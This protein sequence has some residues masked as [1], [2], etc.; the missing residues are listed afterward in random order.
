MRPILVTGISGFIGGHVWAALSARDDVWGIYGSAGR[1]P[2]K[3]DRQLH[4]DLS[5]PDSFVEV[6]EELKPRCILHLA[7]LSPK[8][9]RKN[10][11]NAWKVNNSAVREMAKAA[12]RIGA[13]VI[14]A[15]TDILFDGSGCSYRE[16]DPPN[17]INLYGETKK[18]A[19]RSL[20][21]NAANTVVAR[22]ANAYG[23]PKFKGSS[24]S[25]WILEREKKREPITLF[26]DQYRSFIDIVT[27]T[28]ALVELIDHSFKGLLHLGGANRA[29][30]VTFGEMLLNYMKRDSSGI[31][32]LRNADLDPNS[33]NPLDVSFDITLARQVLDT[34]IPGI[35]KGIALVY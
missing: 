29:N 11:I 32:R 12:E 14:L 17:P 7:A 18:S 22:I 2:L 31:V 23:P 5:Q 9:C 21:A 16:G 28:N 6:I 33:E 8:R 34:V 10:A 4:L 25:E 1:V 30:R 20:F 19:E 13:R 15:S 26:V 24:F 27:L 3:P 35:E